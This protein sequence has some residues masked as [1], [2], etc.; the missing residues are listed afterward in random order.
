VNTHIAYIIEGCKK[1]DRLA[2]KSLFEMYA[3]KLLTVSRQYT[4]QN[5]D[6]LDN[7]Q[8]SF[9]KIFDKLESFDPN[10]GSFDGWAR[11]VV[12]NTSLDKLNKKDIMEYVSNY[13]DIDTHSNDHITEEENLEHIMKL[14]ES[15][16]DGYK[17][18]FCLFEIEGYT[19]KE[20]AD[21]LNIKEA[22][23]RS[24]LSRSKQLLQNLLRKSE[25]HVLINLQTETRS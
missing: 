9:I 1:G 20:I 6:P 2:Q 5:V 21:Q 11:K 3:P 16:P 4:P 8:D 15:L 12:I 25:E 19:H 23:S 17:Q 7:L 14:I 10:K 22:T 13:E 18:V 24:Q